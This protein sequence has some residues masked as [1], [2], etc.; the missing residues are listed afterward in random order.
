MPPLKVA[1]F[2]DKTL[3]D[4]IRENVKFYG[5][6]S[7]GFERTYC[8]FCGD[9]SRTQ[10][11]RGGFKFEGD[12]VG[13]KC[14]NCG[15]TGSYDPD[16]DFP[17]TKNFNKILEAFGIKKREYL[18]FSLVAKKKGGLPLKKAPT[19]KINY[20]DIPDF[21]IPLRD[22]KGHEDFSAAIALLNKKRMDPFNGDFYL[23]SG[24]TKKDDP[25]AKNLAKSLKGRV[26][27]AGTW[28]ERLYFFEGRDLYGKSKSKYIMQGDKNTAIYGLD[29]LSKNIKMP[30]FVTEGYFDAK[31]YGGCAVLTNGLTKEKIELLNR[32]PREKVVIPDKNNDFHNLAVEAIR[33]G[34][35]ITMPSMNGCKDLTE[36]IEK[37]GKIF[38]AKELMKNKKK[39][40]LALTLLSSWNKS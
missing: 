32:S 1:F 7:T 19:V 15:A 2:M 31:H 38:M 39:G 13:Y 6:S 40:E 23:S 17:F 34:W 29:N 26:I 37:N 3:Q 11:P 20:F 21:F 8:E 18:K 16:R 9:G 36:A 27:I 30:L 4:I 12:C 33:A 28:R 5:T 25:K 14:F 24:I 22:A 10:G 35:Y